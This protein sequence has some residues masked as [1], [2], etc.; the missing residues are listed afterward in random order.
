[1][2]DN[3]IMESRRII[4]V[5]CHCHL[6]DNIIN[7]IFFHQIKNYIEENNIIINYYCLEQ[8]HDNVKDFN[9]SENIIIKK[10]T[11]DVGY[12]LW[13][14]TVQK[15]PIA[16]DHLCLMFNTFLNNHNIPIR[17]DTFEYKD[18]DLINR[19]QALDEIHKNIEILIV[20]STPLSGQYV[21]DRD[22]WNNFLIKLSKK[23]VIATT[24][25]VN[26]DIISLHNISV[27]NIAA[28]ATNVKKIIAV[29]TG[30]SLPLYNT[31]ILDNI[32]VLHLF[33]AGDHLFKTR[34]FKA[35]YNDRISDVLHNML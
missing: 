22:D 35:Y 3:V 30:P 18:N 11:H 4:N 29:N 13:Q 21:Y 26:D 19:Y 8:Y 15:L 5:Q 31:D 16:E 28:I 17:V 2:Y 24:Q 9:C 33:G 1:M 12:V 14:A 23:Y 20:N 34:K 6:G 25:K 32:E 7:F 10:F 27:K